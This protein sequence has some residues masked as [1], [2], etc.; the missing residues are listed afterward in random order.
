MIKVLHYLRGG[1]TMQMCTGH[2]EML[3]EETLSLGLGDWIATSG[4]TAALQPVSY[5]HLDVYKRQVH[6]CA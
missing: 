4:E 1:V 5:T 3:K 2:W 6:Y